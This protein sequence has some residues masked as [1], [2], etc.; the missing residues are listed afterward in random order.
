MPA[1]ESVERVLSGLVA[2]PYSGVRG[3]AHAQKKPESSRGVQS[4]AGGFGMLLAAQRWGAGCVLWCAAGCLY[5]VC[6]AVLGVRCLDVTPGRVA[7]PLS[8]G[9]LRVSRR[10]SLPASTHVCCAD[11]HSSSCAPV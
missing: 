1:S 11:L 3:V 2:K 8:G 10:M 7:C 4:G 5:A 9:G 6:C